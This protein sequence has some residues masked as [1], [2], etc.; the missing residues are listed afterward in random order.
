[1]SS[2]Q[3]TPAEIHWGTAPGR[4]VLLATVLGSGVAFLD[5]TVVNVA[6]AAIGRDLGAGFSTLQWVLDAYLLILGAFVLVGG[7][8]GDLFGRRR[9]FVAGLLLFVVASIGCGLAPTAPVLVAGRAVQGLGAA[10]LVPGSLAILSSSFA[11]ADRGRAIGAWSGL[12]GV[13]TAVGPFLGGYLVD[14]VS[15]RW[16]FLINVP[17]VA[18]AVGIALRHVPE[19]RDRAAS[20]ARLDLPGAVTAVVGL[21]LVVFALIEQPRLAAGAVTV[22]IAA[23][24][25]TLSIFVGIEARRTHPMLPLS[26]FRSRDFTVANLTTLAVYAALGA[27][28]FLVVLELQRVLRYSALASGAALLPVTVLLLLLSPAAGALSARVGPRLPMTVGPLLAGVGLLLLARIGPGTTYLATVLPAA[29]AFGGGLALTVAPLTT[30][31]LAAV[32]PARAGVASGVSNAAARIA[33][34]VA[35]AVVPLL[36]GLSDPA[37]GVTADPAG[38]AFTAGFRRA[39]LLAAGGCAIGGLISLFGFR[40]RPGRSPR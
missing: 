3:D 8:L 28:P 37:T 40:S 23:G 2:G 7:V 25:V 22:L 12:S 6:L 35:I 18:A 5:G 11:E 10:L 17:L 38:V 31:V 27:A 15:W 14:A 20:T 19:T 30:T 9:I 13:S 4:W 1:V 32:E 34:L 36:A 29:T 24:V 39:M 21:G 16:V 33:G 26:L